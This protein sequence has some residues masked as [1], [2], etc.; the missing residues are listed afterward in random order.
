MKLYHVL[1]RSNDLREEALYTLNQLKDKHTDLYQRELAKYEDRP[2]VLVQR[3]PHLNCAWGD[4]VFFSPVHPDEV[5]GAMAKHGGRYVP[6]FAY[7]EI[8]S[9]HLNPRHMA[10]WL[11]H[12]PEYDPDEVVRFDED[13]LEDMQNV[14]EATIEYFE[15]QRELE[16]PKM[17]FFM[18]IPHIVHKGSVD[19]SPYVIQH[20]QA[21]AAR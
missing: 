9:T 11:F 4:V 20:T 7:Y 16:K 10:V 8:P 17:F 13:L 15:E 2:H 18:H 14:P 1:V 21:H 12:N 3:F 5:C 19:M 6:S